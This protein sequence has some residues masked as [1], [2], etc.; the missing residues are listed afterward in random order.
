MQPKRT[1]INMPYCKSSKVKLV[2]EGKKV[3]KI[4]LGFVILWRRKKHSQEIESLFIIFFWKT[5]PNK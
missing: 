2:G 4:M 1:V 5:Y 3:T